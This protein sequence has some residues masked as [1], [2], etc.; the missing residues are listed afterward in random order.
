MLEPNRPMARGRGSQIE[1]PNRFGGTHH[2]IDFE[3]LEHDEDY[4]ESLQKRS[5]EYLPD[6]SRTIVA[7]ERQPRRGVPLQHQPVSR[8]RARL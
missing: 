5:T 1:P 7:R 3:H 4:L 2:E 8:L 6:R